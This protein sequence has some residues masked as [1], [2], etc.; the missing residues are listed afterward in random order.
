MV[1]QSSKCVNSQFIARISFQFWDQIRELRLNFNFWKYFEFWKKGIIKT[2]YL[3]SKILGTTSA[4][5]D[6]SICHLNCN[7]CVNTNWIVSY[8]FCTSCPLKKLKKKSQ[9]SSLRPPVTMECGDKTHNCIKS[10]WMV[11][12]GTLYLLL[13]VEKNWN[14]CIIIFHKNYPQF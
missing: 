12:A 5:W 4:T 13:W 14:Y 8:C 11:S 9:K 2:N 6:L 1:N 7:N 10:S 3:Q